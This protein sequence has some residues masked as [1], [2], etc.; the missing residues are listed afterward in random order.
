M[1][2]LVMFF[3][4]LVVVSLAVA[5]APQGPPKPGPEHNKMEYFVGQWNAE[6]NSQ[7]SDFGPA[8]KGT[9]TETCRWLPGG[10]FIHCDRTEKGPSGEVQS[11]GIM[12]YDANEK[13]YT[14]YG[15]DSMGGAF[16]AKGTVTG[17]V[18]AWTTTM[19]MGAKTYML[20][21]V[22]TV[23]PPNGQSFKFEAAEGNGPMK[24]ISEGKS[25]RAK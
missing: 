4:L 11:G 13:V 10:F 8:G 2:R 3:A 12:G 1:K 6:V 21:F 19:K 15:V 20:K 7:A 24:L 5:Q 23:T 25:T 22:A 14:Y 18:W 16:L 17:N 9:G